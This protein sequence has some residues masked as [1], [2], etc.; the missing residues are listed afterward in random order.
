VE[1]KPPC[2]N[3]LAAIGPWIEGACEQRHRPRDGKPYSILSSRPGVSV[4][5]F[6][7]VGIFSIDRMRC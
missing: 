5:A 2:T 6:D 7:A 4:D 1:S 3:D